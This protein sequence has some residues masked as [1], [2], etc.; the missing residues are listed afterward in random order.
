MGAEISLH[1]V[2]IRL[3]LPA[4]TSGNMHVLKVCLLGI[5]RNLKWECPRKSLPVEL[6][7]EALTQVQVG[8]CLCAGES[9]VSIFKYVPQDLGLGWRSKS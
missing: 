5:G 4:L 3:L 6:F 9:L 7:G 1:V 2:E 8:V